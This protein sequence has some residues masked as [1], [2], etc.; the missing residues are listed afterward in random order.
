MTNSHHNITAPELL[1]AENQRLR[2]D[3]ELLHALQLLHQSITLATTPAQIHDALAQDAPVPLQA[4]TALV[5]QQS[6]RGPWI[7]LTGPGGAQLNQRA[8][9]VQHTLN[10]VAQHFRQTAPDTPAG[11]ATN[12][13]HTLVLPVSTIAQQ[14]TAL[15]LESL[16]PWTP[17]RLELA[18]AL[19][20]HADHCLQA[21]AN[22]P[23]KT[24]AAAA[25]EAAT[26]VPAAFAVRHKRRLQMAAV[27][28]VIALLPL[29]L[30]IPAAGVLEPVNRQRLYAPE[31]GIVTELPVSDGHSVQPGDILVRLRSDDL[32]LQQAELLGALAES[33]ARLSA[34]ETAAARSSTTLNALSVESEQAE[35][36]ARILS[37]EQQRTVLQRRM[38]SL[39][40]R[41]TSAGTVIGRDLQQRFVGRP[42]QRGQLLLD[43]V[44][45]ESPWH[46]Q[47]DIAETDL[48]H[49]LSAFQNGSRAAVTVSYF[50][51]TSP[52]QER[53]TQLASIGT[54]AELNPRGEWKTRITT[55]ATPLT[56]AERPGV[57]V[58]ASVSCGRRPLLYVLLRRAFDVARRTV[59]LQGVY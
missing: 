35:L 6:E 3:L 25:S 46:L 1:L 43:V 17:R 32:E 15:C 53:S 41:A 10:A 4:H 29:Q 24:T 13:T 44:A 11:T 52:E 38:E 56:T 59:L 58:Q 50:T 47:L 30:K 48:R 14:T 45:A 54:A 57:G 12:T 19:V 36:R 27:A 31:S 20:R 49:V 21:L 28:L 9:A 37:L 7:A 39:I 40:L 34:L 55:T 23:A 22:S 51:E 2:A 33:Q 8:D 26:S 18:N 42:L 5:C 16:T